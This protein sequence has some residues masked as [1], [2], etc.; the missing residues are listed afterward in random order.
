MKPKVI[1]VHI[2]AR[3]HYLIPKALQLKGYLSY[4]ITDT[5]IASAAL[6]LGLAYSPVRLVKSFASR[7]SSAISSSAVKRFSLKFLAIEIMLRAKRLKGWDLIIARN[8]YFENIAEKIIRQLPATDT[9]LGISYTSLKVF[10]VASQRNQKKILFQ[11]DPGLKE[12]Q[13]VADIV[14]RYGDV[15]TTY[16]E[17]APA[18]YWNAWRKE[19]ALADVIMANSLWS[20]DALIEEGI[21]EQKIKVVPLPFQVQN[22]HLDFK[23]QYPA[24]FSKERPLRCLFLGTLTLRKGVHLVLEVASRLVNAPVEFILVGQNELDMKLLD[25]PNVQYKGVASRADTDAYYQSSDVFLFPTL[26]DGFGLTQLEAM[27]WQL[28]VIASKHCGEVVVNQVNG[29][30]LDTC[31]ADALEKALIKC[32]EQPQFLKKTASNCLETVKQFSLE[33]FADSLAKLTEE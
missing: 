29:L 14:T 22:C 10:K 18:S 25:K 30:E 9:V 16:W 5:W 2:G 33:S 8:N 12:E 19:C 15:Y 24:S 31:N 4:L 3:A 32:L 27:A 13:I 11:I 20:K 6:R 17:P 21:E 7:Y 28:P 1:C 23:R 26:S